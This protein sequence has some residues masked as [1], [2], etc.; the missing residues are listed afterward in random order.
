MPID[1]DLRIPPDDFPLLVA[2]MRIW[3]AYGE[4]TTEDI[5]QPLSDRAVRTI[6][7][8]ILRDLE[9]RAKAVGYSLPYAN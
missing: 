3:K 2:A 9:N 5:K 6:L 1:R 8:D 4:Q 7:L